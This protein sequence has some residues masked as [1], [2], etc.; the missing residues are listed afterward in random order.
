[1]A[2]VTISLAKPTNIPAMQVRKKLG[3]LMDKAVYQGR[4]FIVERAGE[5]AI[6]IVPITQYRQ[7]MA[8]E[9]AE[10]DGFFA[11]VDEARQRFAEVSEDKANALIE[12]AVSAVRTEMRQERKQQRQV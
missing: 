3:E 1:M 8:R 11:M 6:A 9:Q 12:E 2:T 4:S 7:M 10:R 5:A